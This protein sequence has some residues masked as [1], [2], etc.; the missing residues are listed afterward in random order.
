[1]TERFNGTND[2]KYK[3]DPF[4]L[5][6]GAGCSCLLNVLFFTLCNDEKD[7]VLIPTPYYPGFTIDLAAM[8]Q[9][10]AFPME[11]LG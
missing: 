2:K 9:I 1:M 11:T 8:A 3:F 6:I 5:V 10:P 7:A 4:N